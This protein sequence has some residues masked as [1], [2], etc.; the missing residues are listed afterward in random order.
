MSYERVI[1]C[2]LIL[3]M[4]EEIFFLLKILKKNH[5]AKK[6]SLGERNND[7]RFFSEINFLDLYDT[8]SAFI[9]HT[10]VF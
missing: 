8:L 6:F 5:I 9:K 7:S 4:I 10:V 3:W 2:T 1:L